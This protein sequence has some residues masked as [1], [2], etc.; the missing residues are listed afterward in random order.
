MWQA[1][2]QLYLLLLAL[3]WMAAVVTGGGLFLSRTNHVRVALALLL[4]ALGVAVAVQ[5]GN[6]S[7]ER[8]REQEAPAWV[9]IA[10]LS[11]S[12]LAC[13]TWALVATKPTIHQRWCSFLALMPLMA[14]LPLPLTSVLA[15]RSLSE[16]ATSM[17][18]G[19]PSGI[20]AGHLLAA[21]NAFLI[22]SLLLTGALLLLDRRTS[23]HPGVQ[24][25]SK[26]LIFAA[27]WV[28]ILAAALSPIVAQRLQPL[29]VGPLTLLSGCILL[30]YAVLSH[31]SLSHRS[32]LRT[33][34]IDAMEEGLLVFDGSGRLLDA[35]A[36]ARH[37]FA[38]PAD[39]RGARAE[40]VLRC[41][42]VAALLADRG[43]T[44]PQ[45][46][47]KELRVR[48]LATQIVQLY[49]KRLTCGPG[50][51]PVTFLTCRDLTP[52]RQQEQIFQE[53][54]GLTGELVHYSPLGIL[55]LET[56]EGGELTVTAGNPA[57]GL[58]LEKASSSLAGLSLQAAG[59]DLFKTELVE[60]LRAVAT[61][62]VTCETESVLRQDQQ[63]S[64]AMEIRGFQIGP[65]R[66]VVLLRDI[67]P[68]KRAEAALDRSL[69]F[70]KLLM[71]I[72]SSLINAPSSRLDSTIQ[73]SLEAV[74]SF[75]GVDRAYLFQMD[76]ERSTLSNTHEWCA[77]GIQP[78]IEN[79]KDIPCDVL[80]QFVVSIT[81]GRIVNIPKVDALD[82]T[83]PFRR[84]VAAQGIKTLLCVPLHFLGTCLG[85]IGFDCIRKEREWDEQSI[86]LLRTLAELLSNALMRARAEEE[87]RAEHE[88][89]LK[90][91]RQLFH[92]QKLESLGVLA[93][94]VAHY[95]NNLLTTMLGNLSLARA[96]SDK[97][98]TLL[99]FLGNA[100]KAARRAADLI[101]Q[102]LAF[103]GKGSYELADVNLTALVR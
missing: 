15:G 99:A 29:V 25:R 76:V 50:Q 3:V 71:Q 2:A 51:D 63:I 91:E 17:C 52:P 28:P 10:T 35:N 70:Q 14:T 64:R 43:W 98:K 22:T 19:L 5:G 84:M 42:E 39:F 81:A 26:G 20:E 89:I 82:P 59:P 92:A 101:R 83:D 49:L 33:M 102:M 60:R 96:H 11:F 7:P 48:E 88:H 32:I 44:D 80:Q 97:P 45:S 1:E 31:P 47:T 37:L 85:F 95:F 21:F 68:R 103:A 66:A 86:L 34:A 41:S 73:E 61:L 54:A 18:P 74:G 79:L 46:L 55:F 57:S 13:I 30:G 23:D 87:M 24:P 72:S 90:L 100:E 9:C 36:S 16:G 12:S 58:L 27:A 65:G 77:A 40:A 78:E 38:L 56:K 53:A 4:A 67:T 69:R 75:C 94:G 8:I 62:G 6:A 93:G